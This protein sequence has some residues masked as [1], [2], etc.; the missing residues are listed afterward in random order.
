MS[1]KN[2]ILL[3]DLD[4]FFASVEQRDHPRLQGRP[5]IVGGDPRGRGVVSTCS[6]QAREFGVRS[7]MPVKKALELCP[8]AVLLPVNM[9]RYVEVSGQV[10]EILERFTPDIEHVSID[11]AY[12][13]VKKGAG[14]Q[15]GEAIRAAV[16]DELNLP[17]SVGV[18]VNKLLSK[19]A[20]ELAKPDG[21]G[22]LWPEEVPQLFWPLPVT[23]IPG[24]GP[25]TGKK[26]DGYGIRTVRDLAGF[27]ADK[28]TALLGNSAVLLQQFA[29]G[30]DHRKLEMER[31]P[32]SISEETTF[33]ED[34][35]D[36]DHILTVLQELSEGVGYRLRVERFS[37]RT[38]TLKLRFGDFRT[39]TRSQTLAEPVNS[40]FDIYRTVR[41]LF[42]KHCGKPPWRLVGVKASGFER[43]TQ[44]S[45]LPPTPAEQ[46][47]QTILQVKDQLRKK[48]DADVLYQAKRLTRRE[49]EDK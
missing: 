17:V 26:L 48:Y 37:A 47:E 9:P 41:D 1:G 25:A 19:V 13:A 49:P 34:V 42:A 22:T 15:T 14:Y 35:Y 43:G 10:R 6:Y 45:L 8:Q 7:A 21:I 44:I 18:S 28:L 11:E 23:V 32:K 24:I 39:I 2:D 29:L 40:D 33:S 5:V 36:G 12:L 20:C 30:V 4:A 38:I 31:D 16:K 27:P 46:K 3:C